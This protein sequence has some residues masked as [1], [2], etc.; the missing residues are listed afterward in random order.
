MYLEL[1]FTEKNPE[2]WKVQKYLRLELKQ[3]GKIVCVEIKTSK[4]D[5]LCWIW[6]RDN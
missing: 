4:K 5:G 3:V 1:I 6:S 2:R